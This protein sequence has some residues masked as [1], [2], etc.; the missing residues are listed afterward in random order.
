MDKQLFLQ[1]ADRLRKEYEQ[2]PIE[3]WKTI[4]ESWG[5]CFDVDEHYIGVEI[6]LLDESNEHWL[7][8]LEIYV[9]SPAP[10]EY[11]KCFQIVVNKS[12]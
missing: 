6:V 1:I 2:K 12:D 9:P 10:H 8:C 4:G 3:F 5:D 11:D 7:F